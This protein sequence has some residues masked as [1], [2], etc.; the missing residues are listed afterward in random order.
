MENKDIPFYL[1]KPL[2]TETPK[3]EEPPATHLSY[4]GAIPYAYEQ[5]QPRQRTNEDL[6]HARLL[7]E[8]HQQKSMVVWRLLYL[9]KRRQR[10]TDSLASATRNA[11][12]AAMKREILCIAI[13]VIAAICMLLFLPLK[14]ALL[15]I[16][17]ACLLYIIYLILRKPSIRE[18]RGDRIAEWNREL[19]KMQDEHEELE[20]EKEQLTAE[21]KELESLMAIDEQ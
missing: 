17:T 16:G 3:K 7:S 6:A 10:I 5:H 19:Q 13:A 20:Q 14:R 21:I 12:N 15:C 9:E 18:Y 2:K 8:K 1:G 11:T 4:G